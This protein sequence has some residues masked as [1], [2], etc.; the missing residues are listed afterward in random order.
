MTSPVIPQEASQGITIL[1][2][3]DDKEDRTYWSTALRN[4][5]YQYA[6]LEADSGESGFDLFRQHAVDCVVLELNM[7]ESG[8]FTLVRLIPDTKRPHVPLV[9]LT[10]LMHPPL[11]E[12]AQQCGSYACMVKPLCSPEEL[13]RTIQQAIAAVKCADNEA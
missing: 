4:S 10:R 9:V 12:L 7:P 1:L 13:T 2:I 8:F 11:F 3:D 6:V 5:P